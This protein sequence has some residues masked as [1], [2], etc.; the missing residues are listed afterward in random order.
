[1]LFFKSICISKLFLSCIWSDATLPT[2]MIRMFGNDIPK[3]TIY[4]I[5]P[6]MIILL[7]PFVAA[8][9][10][11]YKFVFPILFV[12]VCF[13]SLFFSSLSHFDM[14]HYGGYITGISPLPLA[15]STSIWGVCVFVVALSLGETIWSPRFSLVSRSIYLNDTFFSFWIWRQQSVRLFHVHCTRRS[16]SHLFGS[17]FCSSLCS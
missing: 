14:I 16:G 4:S 11:R 1:M 8:F 2:Y 9:T 13:F 17:G 5:N 6:A 15:L 3:G 10:R 7:T 12:C